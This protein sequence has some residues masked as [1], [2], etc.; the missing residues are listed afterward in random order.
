MDLA[1]EDQVT[2]P[3]PAQ[4]RRRGLRLARRCRAFLCPMGAVA[5]VR[6]KRAVSAVRRNLRAFLIGAAAPLRPLRAPA[7]LFHRG[8]GAPR[9]LAWPGRLAA[10][11]TVALRERHA[12]P[13]LVGPHLS[14][15][16]ASRAPSTL[17]THSG[18]QSASLL[19]KTRRGRLPGASQTRG[20][21][22]CVLIAALRRLRPPRGRK[23]P[24]SAPGD[25]PQAQRRVSRALA[26]SPSGWGA[27]PP[28][29]HTCTTACAASAQRPP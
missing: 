28:H 17:I 15:V 2:R 5:A 16:G 22:A 23:A 24:V 14:T 12:L 18:L 3:L 21:R 11:T 13:R 4:A 10:R 9:C 27:R 6:L 7:C 26:C 25:H 1:E 8:C 20:A 19:S 29:T